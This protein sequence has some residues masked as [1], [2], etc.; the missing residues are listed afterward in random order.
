[1]KSLRAAGRDEV[2]ASFTVVR[3][4][5]PVIALWVRLADKAPANVAGGHTPGRLFKEA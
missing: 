3:D 5:E 2:G 4:G 1:V